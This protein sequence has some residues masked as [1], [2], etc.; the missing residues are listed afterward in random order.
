MT[1]GRDGEVIFAGPTGMNRFLFDEPTGY[2]AAVDR[3][4]PQLRQPAYGRRY[5]NT[6]FYFFAEDTW[7]VG[8][9]VLNAGLRYE[10]FGAPVNTGAVK[11]TLVRLGSGASFPERIAS[12]TLIVSG[13]GDQKLWTADNKNLAPRFCFA[14]DPGGNAPV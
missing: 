9:V 1:T 3:L 4:S 2:S 10:N 13:P 5:W 7:R 6:Q 14:W 11:D 8:R 12:A